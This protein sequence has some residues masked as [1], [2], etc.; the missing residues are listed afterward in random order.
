MRYCAIEA[1][2]NLLDLHI[3]EDH[4]YWH[5]H[6]SL[7]VK[8]TALY[9]TQP[10]IKIFFFF[11]QMTSRRFPVDRKPSTDHIPIEPASATPTIDI[12]SKLRF[13]SPQSPT[14]ATTTERGNLFQHLL[15]LSNTLIIGTVMI[16]LI[17]NHF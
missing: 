3:F 1:H 10:R 6:S 16:E 7:F 4:W 12:L 9:H 11:F 15:E 5:C 14:I 17:N 13:E 2:A 8:P